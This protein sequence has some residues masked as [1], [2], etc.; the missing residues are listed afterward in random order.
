[1][2]TIDE[3]PLPKKSAHS[4]NPALA[5]DVRGPPPQRDD[6]SA[7]LA[8]ALQQLRSDVVAVVSQLA[9]DRAVT[10]HRDELRTQLTRDVEDASTRLRA[11]VASLLDARA[12]D[13]SRRVLLVDTLLQ[14]VSSRL[15][16]GAR[17]LDEVDR[18]ATPAHVAALVESAARTTAREV[19][20]TNFQPGMDALTEAFGDADDRLQQLRVFVDSFGPGGLPVVAQERDAL[21]T[22]VVALAGELDGARAEIYGLKVALADRDAAALRARVVEGIDPETLHRRHADLADRERELET[23]SALETEN[24]RLTTEIERL[25]EALKRWEATGCAE[26]EARVDAAD[27]QRWRTAAENAEQQ[28]I[29]AVRRE[30][31]LEAELRHVVETLRGRENELR[32]LEQERA[33]VEERDRRIQAINNE[34]LSFRRQFEEQAR[35][36][37]E[38]ERALRDAELQRS[39]LVAEILSLQREVTTAA[40]SARRAEAEARAEMLQASRVELQ[41]WAEAEAETRAQAHRARADSLATLVD[42][43][44]HGLFAKDTRI[45]ELTRE[46]LEAR[47]K[48]QSAQIEQSALEE[49]RNRRVDLLEA[50]VRASEARV[51]ETAR[52]EAQRIREEADAEATRLLDLAE[53]ANER[54]NALNDETTTLAAHKGELAAQIERLQTDLWDLKQ[55][56]VPEAERL[57]SLEARV[58][59][60]ADLPVVAHDVEEGPW[61][62]SLMAGISESGFVFH[63]RLVRAFHTSLK[64]AHHAPLVVLAGISGTGKSELPRLYADLGGVPFLP[65]A[66]QPSWDSPHDLFGFFNYTDGRLKA[67]PLARLFR[68]VGAEDDALRASPSLVLLDEMNLARV[69]YYFADLLSKLEARRSVRGSNDLARRKRASVYMDTGPNGGDIHLYLDDRVLFVGTMNQDESTLTLSDKVLDRASVLTFP[70]PRRMHLTTQRESPRRPTRLA[71]ETWTRWQRDPTKGENEE[72][73]NEVNRIMADL[74][75]PF[76]HRLFRAIHAYVENYPGSGEAAFADQFAMKILP[77][78]GGLEAGTNRVKDGL[79]ALGMLVPDELAS[80]FDAARHHEFFTWGG[81]P[82]LYQVDRA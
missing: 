56:V 8:S 21:R 23:R 24:R 72:R 59:A 17:K 81:A 40:E 69:E 4:T 36:Q 62:D 78:L 65:L 33:I 42:E 29:A 44:E 6:A 66:V 12:D 27:L 37:S 55:R 30:N 41:R 70:A 75:R 19:Y 64:I 7:A 20:Q 15:A 25:R 50:E 60:A 38:Q 18:R 80:A 1:M 46:C 43:L 10:E 71:W 61:L 51:L 63:D 53:G 74:G 14:E 58:F 9:A 2:L 49:A 48:L 11:E 34:N 68:Q 3:V 31:R 67:E 39:N 73:L 5:S 35:R 82:D 13:L 47:A 22:R 45:A 28:R 54:R 16:E 32:A 57:Q 79:D 76:G 77:R 26:Q 52:E